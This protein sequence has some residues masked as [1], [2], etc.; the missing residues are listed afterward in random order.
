MIHADFHTHSTLDDGKSTL[1]E[2]AAAAHAMGLTRFGFSGHSYCPWEE[3]YCIPQNRVEEYLATARALREKYAGEMEIFVGMELDYYGQRPEGLDYAIGSVHGMFCNG[4]FYAVDE[5]PE[6]S[7]RTVEEAF[8]GDWYR[9]TDAYF[10]LVAQLPEKTGCDWIGHFDLVSKFNQQDPHFDEES[11]RYWKRAL[12]VME[13]LVKQGMCFEVNTGAI[14]RGYR[15]VPYPAK[16]MLR[17][18]KDLGGEIIL[19][20][21]A[22]H[23]DHLCGGFQQ[24]EELIKEVGFTHVNVWTRDGFQAVGLLE[25]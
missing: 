7:R 23:T 21:D 10:D 9:Y 13:C 14:T 20:S 4:G 5:S 15:T 12:E 19:N 3:D 22:H 6:A 17:R 18:L 16:T 25:R 2:M 24:A 8:G 11:P 1:A